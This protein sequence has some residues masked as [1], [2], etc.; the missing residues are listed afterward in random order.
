M[1]IIRYIK[2]GWVWLAT[3]ADTHLG[4]EE[5][6]EVIEYLGTQGIEACG[7]PAYKDPAARA[8][9]AGVL[10]VWD[11][12]HLQAKRDGKYVSCVC[13]SLIVRCRHH[14]VCPASTQYRVGV[15]SEPDC[16]SPS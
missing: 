3:L 7:T 4:E 12:N 1:E 13:V 9:K 16:S 11:P 2:E 10:I 15:Q 5:M 8:L 14:P 6:R